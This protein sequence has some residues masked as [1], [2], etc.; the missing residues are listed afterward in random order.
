MS[1]EEQKLA[2]KQQVDAQLNVV[3]HEKITDQQIIDRLH[4]YHTVFL[5]ELA[6]AKALDKKI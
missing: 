6:T 4:H 2:E 3:E 1:F 5:G